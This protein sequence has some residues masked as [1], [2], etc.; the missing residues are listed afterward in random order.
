MLA[1]AQTGTGTTA[2]FGLPMLHHLVDAGGNKKP[3]GLILSPTR[4]LCVQ[5]T[6]EMEKYAAHMPQIRIMAAYG[7]SSVRDQIQSLKRG[8][9]IVV[10]TPGRLKDLI[11]R[12]AMDLSQVETVVLDESD[13]MLNMGFLDDVREILGQV[14][15]DSATWLFSAT[16]PREI[17][18]IIKDFM[19]FGYWEL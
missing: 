9:D 18:R 12:R 15:E 13:E 6:G 10:A 7:G 11:A 5:I 17:E 16:L 8:V 3:K 1:L 14:R 19:D 4:E 2:A